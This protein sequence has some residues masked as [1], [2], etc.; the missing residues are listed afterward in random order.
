MRVSEERATRRRHVLDE[1]GVLSWDDETVLPDDR[2]GRSEGVVHRGA[3]RSG[4]RDLCPMPRRGPVPGV[5]AALARAAWH[6]GRE[7]ARRARAGTYSAFDRWV[8][9][10]YGPTPDPIASAPGWYVGHYFAGPLDGVTAIRDRPRIVE[11][12][13]T[14]WEFSVARLN[15]VPYVTDDGQAWIGRWEMA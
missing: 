4:Q 8:H 6:L 3:G 15:S 13:G 2:Q 5:C 10:R 9:F 7:G 14:V 12:D 1:M 11:D